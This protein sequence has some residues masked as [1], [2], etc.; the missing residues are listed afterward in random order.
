[1]AAAIFSDRALDFSSSKSSNEFE[2]SHV[3]LWGICSD[4]IVVVVHDDEFEL[5]Y[6]F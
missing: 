4:A 2:D 5:D 3:C 1:M 6:V